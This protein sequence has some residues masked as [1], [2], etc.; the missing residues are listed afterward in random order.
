MTP[1]QYATFT[2]L[3]R[4]IEHNGFSPPQKKLADLVGT[5]QPNVSKLIDRLVERG[6]VQKA[7]NIHCG[8]S[9]TEAGKT[10]WEEIRK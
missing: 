8:L 3:A 10:R 6:L 5:T 2:A 7:P 4:F 1:R 9:L